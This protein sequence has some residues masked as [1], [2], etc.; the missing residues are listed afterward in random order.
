MSM[1]SD[2]EG[3]HRRKVERGHSGNVD[4][5]AQS[6]S[7]DEEDEY[8]VE[9][10]ELSERAAAFL[11]S[12][13]FPTHLNSLFPASLDSTIPNFPVRSPPPPD[14]KVS[15]INSSITQPA[16]PSSKKAGSLFSLSSFYDVSGAKR[17]HGAR[18]LKMIE[19]VSRSTAAVF[20]LIAFCVMSST[21]ERRVAAGSTFEVKFS[22]YQAYNFLVTLN[23]LTFAY[24]SAQV[25]VLLQ[26]CSSSSSSSS[27]FATPLRSAICKYFCDEVLAFCLFSASS[28]AA[29]AS[30]MSRYGLH[31]IWPPA[32]STWKLW[33]FCLKADVAVIISFFSS[34]FVILSSLISGFHLLCIIASV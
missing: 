21:R 9:E 34:C 32:C 12:L 1:A 18:S 7:T 24:S 10:K 25:V 27:I 6:Y 22:D 13:G 2:E 8:R 19:A 31:N 11:D 15:V 29:T 33:L 28:S 23:I 30:E 14:V 3:R 17:F 5:V 16:F 26:S 4:S 20:S